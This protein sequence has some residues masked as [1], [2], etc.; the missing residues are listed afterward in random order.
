MLCMHSGKSFIM[1]GLVHYIVELLQICFVV[2]QGPVYLLAMINCTE[3]PIDIVTVFDSQRSLEVKFFT[4]S[5]YWYSLKQKSCVIAWKIDFWYSLK[6]I[7]PSR[8][9][10]VSWGLEN[11]DLGIPGE[12]KDNQ[13]CQVRRY[14]VSTLSSVYRRKSSGVSYIPV[15]ECA[16]S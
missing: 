7:L 4:Q 14:F 2:W 6:F 11:G 16:L 13:R 5:I 10:I 3:L 8:R 12:M 9:Y 1:R 15:R